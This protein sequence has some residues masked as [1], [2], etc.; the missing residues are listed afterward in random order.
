[1]RPYGASADLITKHSHQLGSLRWGQDV[2][3]SLPRASP[4]RQPKGKASLLPHAM[5]ASRPS[6]TLSSRNQTQV[7]PDEMSIGGGTPAPA[8]DTACIRGHGSQIGRSELGTLFSLA[9]SVHAY[10]RTNRTRRLTSKM[11]AQRQ[12]APVFLLRLCLESNLVPELVDQ[13]TG[14]STTSW[15]ATS[16]RLDEILHLL[17]SHLEL[18]RVRRAVLSQSLARHHDYACGR[19]ETH[20][21]G[22]GLGSEQE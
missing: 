4:G 10:E 2:L 14:T 20:Q 17:S 8:V 3:S 21:Q 18:P 1:M 11:G 6:T 16:Q 13:A 5:A 7:F 15:S 22:T 9:R 19:F 12:E